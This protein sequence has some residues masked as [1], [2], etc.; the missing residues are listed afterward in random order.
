[1]NVISSLDAAAVARL[2]AGERCVLL[3][4]NSL[5]GQAMSFQ[6]G[7]AGRPD[8]NFGTVIAPHPA[9]ARFPHEGFCD[10]Q[11]ARMMTGG[12]AVQFAGLREA[13]EPI[14]EIVSSYKA[15]KPQ[16][17]LFELRVGAGRLLVCTLKLAPS[18]P[19]AAYLRAQL[20]AYAASEEFQPKTSVTAEQ[21]A[22]FM[23]TA[24]SKPAPMKKT[25]EGLDTAGQLPGK[26]G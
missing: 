2:A 7:L 13:F 8:G 9:I 26:K 15:P 25:D 17:A 10:W 4:G 5:P 11:F 6:M 20:L 18:D 14:I 22:K 1:V 19:A 16:A 21:F 23:A 12:T 3:G 24:G